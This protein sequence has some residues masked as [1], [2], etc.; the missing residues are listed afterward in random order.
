MQ[1]CRG[2]GGAFRHSQAAASVPIGPLQ[3]HPGPTAHP[4]S[5]PCR[6]S[7]PE[8]PPLLTTGVLQYGYLSSWPAQPPGAARCAAPLWPRRPCKPRC[9][10]RGVGWQQ[11]RCSTLQTALQAVLRA[12][13]GPP[14]L[15]RCRLRSA[16]GLPAAC[17]LA[18]AHQSPCA[19]TPL[20]RLSAPAI[21]RDAAGRVWPSSSAAAAGPGKRSTWPA[22]IP[23]RIAA[24]SQ[25]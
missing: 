10:W 20:A 5:G 17:F 7:L 24:T 8:C 2:V 9:G 12:G 18:A 22:S 23:R 6:S 1:H 3:A 16:A 25:P 13:A 15:R 21:R 4:S 11:G 19:A 14:P